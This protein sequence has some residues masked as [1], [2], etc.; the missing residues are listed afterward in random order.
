[1]NLALPRNLGGSP[2]TATITLVV[3]VAVVVIMVLI[4]RHGMKK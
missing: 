1:M 3:I 4:V 2:E